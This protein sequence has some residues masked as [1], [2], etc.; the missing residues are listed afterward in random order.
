[1]PGWDILTWNS[2]VRDKGTGKERKFSL[3]LSWKTEPFTEVD[4]ASD[5]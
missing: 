4:I 2:N 1:M 5:D 3:L